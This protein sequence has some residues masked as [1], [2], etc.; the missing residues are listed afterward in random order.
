MSRT[1][2]LLLFATLLFLLYCVVFIYRSSF[3]GIDGKRYFS[4]FDD[5][6]VSM[7]YAWNFSHGN[8]LLWNP[9]EMV[10][11][12]SNFLWTL[13]MSLVTR[14]F[15]KPTSV[16]VVQVIGIGLLLGNAYIA[17]K[18]SGYLSDRR[19]VVEQ[20][21]IKILSFLAPILYFPLI[22][23]TLMGMETG[24]ITTLTLASVLFLLKY[25]KTRAKINLLRITVFSCA[26]ILVRMD[27]LVLILPIWVYLLWDTSRSERRS[28][29]FFFLPVLAS[30]FALLLFQYTYYGS[31][32]PNT[33]TL[34]LEG[35]P[36]PIRVD[37]GWTYLLPFLT[38]VSFPILVILLDL[39]SNFTKTK[40]MLFAL[41]F[42]GI[43]YQIYVGGDAW[44]RWRLVAPIIPVVLILFIPAIVDIIHGISK[45]EIYGSF[46]NRKSLMTQNRLIDSVL[47]LF[48]VVILILNIGFLREAAILVPVYDVAANKTVINTAIILDELTDQGATIG[49]IRAGSLPYYLDRFAI[50]FL[51]KSDEHIASLLPKYG[52]EPNG[53]TFVPGHNKYNL[54]Y[55]IQRLRPTYI[56]NTRWGHDNLQSW[57]EDHYVEVDY[58]GYSILLLR[59]SPDVYWEKIEKTSDPGQ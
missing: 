8:G 4:L 52:G 12:Y 5:A 2:K 35:F 41:I 10:Q 37:N 17:M 21:I 30:L 22:Y 43:A 7:R 29:L 55:S 1:N 32:L 53:M 48:L 14:F 26:V 56:Q 59:G 27:T 6:M 16:F 46:F 51:G 49:V 38:A 44:P 28:I 3:I 42:L 24:L 50:D 36:L 15:D 23:W 31:L 20:T 57:V 40:L 9:G 47:V 58:L 39:I 11:G 45:S 18:L 19:P 13:S 33:Y 25:R 54:N 34:K